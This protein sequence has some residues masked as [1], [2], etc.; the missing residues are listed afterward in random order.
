MLGFEPKVDIQKPFPRLA[1]KATFC[2]LFQFQ[3]EED[4]ATKIWFG[5]NQPKLTDAEVKNC[6]PRFRQ[7]KFI[8]TEEWKQS[9]SY[10]TKASLVFE[11]N[12]KIEHRE[13][14]LRVAD[15]RY[16]SKTS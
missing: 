10:L 14:L 11:H 1:T 3:E 2:V 9:S 5:A 16:F 12:Q 8:A 7:F 6:P 13:G 4:A 15:V